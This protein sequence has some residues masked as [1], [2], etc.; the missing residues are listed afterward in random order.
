MSKACALCGFTK[1]VAPLA[2]EQ[3]SARCP[4]CG[5]PLPSGVTE[6]TRKEGMA[7]LKQENPA[8]FHHLMRK[9]KQRAAK[10]RTYR[11]VGV[12]MGIALLVVLVYVLAR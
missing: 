6:E 12:V 11:Q 10:R 2:V 9:R 1:D 3:G 7:G 8:L 5:N 4:L